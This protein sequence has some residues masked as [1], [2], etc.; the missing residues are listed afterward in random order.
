MRT[1]LVL[2]VLI[3]TSSPA[4]STC[5]ET[6]TG[7]AR[8][9]DGD[10]VDVAGHR[11]RLASIDAPESRQRCERAGQCAPCGREATERLAHIVANQVVACRVSTTDRYGRCIAEC[12][13]DGR[14][15]NIGMV[16]SGAATVYRRYVGA[17]A[18]RYLDAEARAR[19][20][21]RGLWAGT[22]IDPE[23]WRRGD[24]GRCR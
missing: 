9:I 19:S 5:P 12:E 24:R 16:E 11:V 23:R 1:A 18:V 22:F 6:I 10:T 8:V 20:A 13:A 7:T 3:A 14:S 2:A 17:D 4:W 15:V 21:R